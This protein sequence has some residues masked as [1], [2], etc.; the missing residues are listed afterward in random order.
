M[1]KSMT[2]C[3]RATSQTSLALFSVEIQSVNG[4]FLDIAVTLPSE[5]SFFETEIKKWVANRIRR[6]R[7]RVKVSASFNAA[8]PMTVRPNI[9]LAK[10]V[11]QAWKEIADALNI[12]EAV[13]LELLQQ[14]QG[15]LLFEE[16]SEAVLSYKD[17]LQ[18]VV[19]A[20]LEE[21]EKMKLHEGEA[22][23]SDIH[24]RLKCLSVWI[25]KI[26]L[27][28]PR[29]GEKFRAKLTETL[30]EAFNGAADNL[31]RVLR[32]AGLYAEKVDI[33][34]EVTRF[35]AHLTQFK[36]IIANEGGEGPG[37]KLEFLLQELN[38][39]ANTIASKAQDAEIAHLVVEIKCGLDQI[40]EQLQNIE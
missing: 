38:R 24:D 27:N 26:R 40:K 3:G 35:N 8:S 25:E 14:E 36:S 15:L 20:A 19:V 23:E 13:D 2:G 34:E 9:S 5:L 1:L 7:V 31:E 6:G 12:E 22:L 33:T 28:A 30:N 21:T 16:D 32:E 29:M 39:E 17:S 11:H 4:K 18:Q 37:K 10:Q